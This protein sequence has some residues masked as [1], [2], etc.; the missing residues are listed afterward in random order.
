LSDGASEGAHRASAARQ[1]TL[2]GRKDLAARVRGEAIEPPLEV[3][4]LW[5]YFA[6]HSMGLAINGMAPATVTWEGLRAWCELMG[7]E[8]EPWEA[9]ALVELGSLRARIESEK[10]DRARDSVRPR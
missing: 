7:I 5:E 3:M 6:R 4:Y 1:W 8:L 10:Y 2:M 9:M